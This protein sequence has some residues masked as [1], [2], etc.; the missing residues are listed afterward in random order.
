MCNEVTDA[1]NAIAK[2]YA[3]NSHFQVFPKDISK[4]IAKTI[5]RCGKSIQD[6]LWEFVYEQEECREFPHIIIREA[7]HGLVPRFVHERYAMYEGGEFYKVT[8]NGKEVIIGK[9]TGM[10]FIGVKPDAPQWARDE[11]EE[12][13]DG[14]AETWHFEPK[15]TP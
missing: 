3:D 9:K 10:D 6:E 7:V 11:Y 2:L 5:L 12:W 8:D 14:A 1:K 13:L 15:M 4:K